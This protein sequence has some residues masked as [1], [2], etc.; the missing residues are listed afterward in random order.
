MM[1]INGG[2]NLHRWHISYP[3]QAAIVK[4]HLSNLKEWKTFRRYYTVSR[5]HY[6]VEEQCGASH[7]NLK[8]DPCTALIAKRPEHR[9]S[10]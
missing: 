3:I 1:L 6:T 8:W 9:K 5:N 2:D 10:Y 7:R 4:N